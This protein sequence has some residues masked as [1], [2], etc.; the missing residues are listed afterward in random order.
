VSPGGQVEIVAAKR[1]QFAVEL[2]PLTR[3]DLDDGL[4]GSPAGCLPEPI[5]AAKRNR[6]AVELVLLTRNDL[7]F[8]LQ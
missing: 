6:F 1:N 4:Q 7:D 2:V 8:G 5:V 3:N